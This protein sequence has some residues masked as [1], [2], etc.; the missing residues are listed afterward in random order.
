MNK[1]I[2]H[3]ANILVVDDHPI[4]HQRGHEGGKDG[5]L[6]FGFRHRENAPFLILN[7]AQKN[8]QEQNKTSRYCGSLRH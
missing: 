5:V 4:D 6:Q 3:A 2:E 8:P 7:L 1:I